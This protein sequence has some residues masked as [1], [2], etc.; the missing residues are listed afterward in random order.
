MWSF[1]GVD[2]QGESITPIEFDSMLCW[3]VVYFGGDRCGLMVIYR[4]CRVFASIYIT[5]YTN[6]SI[7]QSYIPTKLL[8]SLI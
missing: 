2:V 7:D 5:Y 4:E 6:R 8:K 1:V 3:S